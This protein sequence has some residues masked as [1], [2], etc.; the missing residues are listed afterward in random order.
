MRDV[1]SMDQQSIIDALG[2]YVEMKTGRKCAGPV[3]IDFM[4]ETDANGRQTGR[5]T[6]H[7]MVE[8]VEPERP[9]FEG[10]VPRD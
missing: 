7:A 4:W 3:Q 5:Q 8:V 1:I 6:I 10:T 9:K 2:Q